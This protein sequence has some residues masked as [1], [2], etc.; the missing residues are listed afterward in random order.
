[1]LSGKFLNSVESILNTD[2]FKNID[3]DKRGLQIYNNIP[4]DNISLI[5]TVSSL[6]PNKRLEYLGLIKVDAKKIDLFG[7]L[8]SDR[9]DIAVFIYDETNKLIYTNS[10]ANENKLTEAENLINNENQSAIYLG[11]RNEIL[12]HEP[13]DYRGWKALF[14]CKSIK[15]REEIVETLILV[16]ISIIILIILFVIFIIIFSKNFSRRFGLL[17]EKMERV[18]NG[19]LEIVKEIPGNDEIA[20]A[21]KN[22]K[23]MVGK[24]NKSILDNYLLEISS[25]EAEL[26]ALQ[27]QINPHFIFNTL[28]CIN[29]MPIVIA[30]PFTQKYFV[31]GIMIGSVKG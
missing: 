15:I 11:S 25:K 7:S 6:D 8:E 9:G 22:F 14:V 28:E 13:L 1:M 19:N 2:W 18:E 30:Y 27:F 23:K 17:I 20:V 10:E 12:I 26:R 21:D 31:N 3:P 4:E 29:S 5:K 24:L 16:I